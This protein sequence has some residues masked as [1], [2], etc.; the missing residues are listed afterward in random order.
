MGNTDNEG[1]RI[2]K[3]FLNNVINLS[4]KGFNFNSHRCSRGRKIGKH[5]S[6]ALKGFIGAGA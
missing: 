5:L 1:E 2:K 3:D 4:L 6:I